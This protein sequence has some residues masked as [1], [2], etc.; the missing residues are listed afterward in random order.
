MYLITEA[1]VM[2]AFTNAC[3]CILYAKLLFNIRLNLKGVMT[4]KM[5]V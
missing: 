5:A 4:S 3:N 1:L 2:E